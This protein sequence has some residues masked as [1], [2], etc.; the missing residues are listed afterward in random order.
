M[1]KKGRKNDKQRGTNNNKEKKK[2]T[3]GG[4]QETRD[5]FNSI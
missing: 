5:E 3:I 4:L 1:Q 2:I